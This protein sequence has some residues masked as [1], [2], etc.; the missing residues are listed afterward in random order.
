MPLDGYTYLTSYGWTGKGNGLRKGAIEKPIAIPQKRNLAGVGKDRD[1]AFPFWDHLFAAA[2]KAITIKVASDDD[3]DGENEND[4]DLPKI[5]P[6]EIKRTST[7]I[8]SNR[9]PV[10]GIPTSE[11]TSGT[12]TPDPYVGPKLS[13]IAAAKREAVKRGL[14][15]RFFRGPI[16]GPDDEPS[17]CTTIP[18]TS[19]S[20]SLPASSE[21][22]PEPVEKKSKRRRSESNAETKEE[23]RERKR[24][25]RERKEARRLKRAAK[26]KSSGDHGVK[27]A[28]IEEGEDANSLDRGSRLK[29]SKKKHK[30]VKE[31]S[32]EVDPDLED[33]MATRK[34]LRDN[35]AAMQDDLPCHVSSLGCENPGVELNLKK[36]KGK[37]KHSS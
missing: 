17:T 16:L 20:P 32:P 11:S 2:S 18:A 12:A 34:R 6:P 22:T 31:D 36:K 7:G 15:S 37:R 1:E 5:E 13:L 19:I 9:R 23:R 14:Y 21:T 33:E 8:I 4:E 25:K 29:P 28:G 30:R 3:D 27:V 24:I 10:L 26:A 35:R